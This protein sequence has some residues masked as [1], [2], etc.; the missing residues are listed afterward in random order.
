MLGQMDSEKS[1]GKSKDHKTGIEEN[2]GKKQRY[3]LFMTLNI[4]ILSSA[5]ELLILS[6][7][8]VMK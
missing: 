3:G 8:V 7:N 4:L 2:L 1:G 5:E 6:T